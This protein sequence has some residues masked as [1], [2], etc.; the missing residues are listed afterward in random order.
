VL[1]SDF[2]VQEAE[3]RVRTARRVAAREE[4][5]A[6]ATAGTDAD[7]VTAVRADAASPSDGRSTAPAS[8]IHRSEQLA[9][10]PTCDQKPATASSRQQAQ[11]QTST[12]SQA[13][14]MLQ[15]HYH[16]P[17][18]DV[19]VHPLALHGRQLS[20]PLRLLDFSLYSM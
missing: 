6:V 5:A 18:P 17:L 1:A 3:R 13:L 2:D 9:A 20:G 8:S 16:A 4:V 11:P 14:A 12:W 7:A 10:S 19:V 15:Q